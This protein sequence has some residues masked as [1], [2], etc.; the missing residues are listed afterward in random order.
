MNIED[1]LRKVANRKINKARVVSRLLDRIDD[2]DDYV[3]LSDKC[4][5]SA[6]TFADVARMMKIIERPTCTASA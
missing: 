2:Y 5:V 4:S 3:W 6:L 1:K